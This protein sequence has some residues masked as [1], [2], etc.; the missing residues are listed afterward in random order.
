MS[1]I[2]EANS[3]INNWEFFKTPSTIVISFDRDQSFGERY[4]GINTPSKTP[5]IFES[6]FIHF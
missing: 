2:R 3:P 6:P 1:R 5:L 4:Y